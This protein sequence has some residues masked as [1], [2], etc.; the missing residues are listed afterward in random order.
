[1]DAKQSQAIDRVL[2]KLS[3]LRMTLNNEE[4]EILDSFVVTVANEVEAH[5]LVSAK[6]PAKT[7]AKAPAKDYETDEMKAQQMESAKSFT[8]DEKKIARKTWAGQPRKIVYDAEKK[9]YRFEN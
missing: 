6:T 9:M 3:V 2:K 1:M 4:R 7:P 8:P 5:Q